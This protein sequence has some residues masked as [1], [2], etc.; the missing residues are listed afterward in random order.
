MC[1]NANGRI[2]EAKQRLNQKS[3]KNYHKYFC[4]KIFNL[5]ILKIK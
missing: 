5:Q 4:K 3:V 2:V 1:I